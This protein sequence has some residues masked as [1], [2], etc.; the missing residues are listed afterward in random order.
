MNTNGD[1]LEAANISIF[2]DGPSF[3]DLTPLY[4]TKTTVNGFYHI[5][6]EPGNYRIW[7]NV[8]E[9]DNINSAFTVIFK[10]IFL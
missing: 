2:K 5:A 3:S 4:R 7:I 6:L 9:F 10:F 8:N 1:R